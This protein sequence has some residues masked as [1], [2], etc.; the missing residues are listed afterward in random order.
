MCSQRVSPLV[1]P[2]R[3]FLNMKN[4]GIN[5]SRKKTNPQRSFLVTSHPEPYYFMLFKNVNFQIKSEK[6]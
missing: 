4:T 2:K 1:I 3:L 6:T 5:E